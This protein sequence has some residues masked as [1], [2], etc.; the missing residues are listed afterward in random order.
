[1][2]YTVRRLYSAIIGSLLTRPIRISYSLSVFIRQTKNSNPIGFDK[3]GPASAGLSS[4]SY[5]CR[6]LGENVCSLYTGKYG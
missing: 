3:A 6:A 1:M 4:P 2:Q 5:G